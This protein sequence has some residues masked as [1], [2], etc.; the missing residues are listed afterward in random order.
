MTELHPCCRRP[1][2]VRTLWV[3]D[4]RWSK[5][6]AI[7]SSN[8]EAPWNFSSPSLKH[9]NLIA[10]LR[11][12]AKLPSEPPFLQTSISKR[13]WQGLSWPRCS[14]FLLSCKAVNLRTISCRSSTVVNAW[15]GV[16]TVGKS[17][18]ASCIKAASTSSASACSRS[19]CSSSK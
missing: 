11:I 14:C 17:W 12:F 1:S 13:L 7:L 4:L 3:K 19:N 9:F 5:R 15:A 8:P 6:K 16:R 18:L 2:A 10:A